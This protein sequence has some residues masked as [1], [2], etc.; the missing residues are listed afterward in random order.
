MTRPLAVLRPEPGNA[1]TVARARAAGFAT[2]ALP[3]FDVR[4][5]AWVPPDPARFDALLLTSA[6]TLRWGGPALARYTGLPVYAVGANTAAAAA[7][8]G[9]SVAL[10]G[11]SDAAALLALASGAGVRRA[12]HLTGRERSGAAGDAVAATVPVYASDAVAIAAADLAPLSHA[13]ALLHSP[14]A[15]RRLGALIDA[16][17]LR[18]AD[19]AIAAFSPAVA[20][21]AGTRWA[22]VAIAAAPTDQALFDAARSIGPPPSH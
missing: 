8:A 16:A 2:I 3:L 20:Q 12:L 6:S 13:T 17:G 21:A 7:A 11:T 14:R 4:P 22:A 9:F 19:L 10:T 1:A 18:R 15:A 5:L